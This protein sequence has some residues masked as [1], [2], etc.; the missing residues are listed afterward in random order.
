MKKKREIL[1]QHHYTLNFLKRIK[2][3]NQ[4]IKRDKIEESLGRIDSFL[5][6]T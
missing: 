6:M 2:N 4:R 1:T 3:H 5:E